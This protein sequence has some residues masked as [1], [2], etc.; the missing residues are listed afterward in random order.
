MFSILKSVLWIVVV[1]ALAYYIM[2]YFGYEIN[3]NYFTYS[4]QK[5]EEKIRSCTDNLIHQGIDNATSKCD[6][7]CVDPQLIINKK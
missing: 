2:G 6:L 5:C 3:K 4:K 7:V 1:L